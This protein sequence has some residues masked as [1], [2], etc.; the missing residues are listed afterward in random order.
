MELILKRFT[1][2]AANQLPVNES[3]NI[4]LF[5][6]FIFFF[7]S[8]KRSRGYEEAVCNCDFFIPDFKKLIKYLEVFY[9]WNYFVVILKTLRNVTNNYQEKA[10]NSHICEAI[11]F[12]PYRFTLDILSDY[13]KIE[14][15]FH[16]KTCV[17]SESLSN[18]IYRFHGD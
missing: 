8:K 15:H 11:N 17:C 7:N 18:V 4:P 13:I 16:W 10:A 14:N 5:L 3:L 2:A 12:P 9:L 1:Q 6:T